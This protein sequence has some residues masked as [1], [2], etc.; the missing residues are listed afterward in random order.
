MHKETYVLVD[1]WENTRTCMEEKIIAITWDNFKRAFLDKYFLEDLRNKK[2][3]NFLELKQG[4]MTMT[5]Y[6]AKYFS[7]YQNKAR[8]HSKC[9]GLCLKIKQETNQFPTLVNK[10]M[11]F[12][13]GY[14]A[15]AYKSV[16]PTKKSRS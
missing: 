14:K 12:Y 5:Y 1:E 9:N 2:E 3:M 6:I 10:C 13:K 4:S 16:G 7:H 15:R 11:I 8:E